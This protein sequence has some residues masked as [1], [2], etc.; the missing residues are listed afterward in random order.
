MKLINQL[1][2]MCS[3]RLMLPC[4]MYTMFGDGPWTLCGS[5]LPEEDYLKYNRNVA[6][7]NFDNYHEVS[8]IHRQTSYAV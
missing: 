2:V 6:N 8:K 4:I 5:Q 7:K 1:M 3:L